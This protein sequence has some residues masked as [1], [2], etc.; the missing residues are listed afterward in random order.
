MMCPVMHLS[1][2]GNYQDT[3][4]TCLNS[5]AVQLIHFQSLGKLSCS[6]CSDILSIAVHLFYKWLESI[7]R[8]GKFWQ[9]LHKGIINSL[10][11]PR[12]RVFLE[13]RLLDYHTQNDPLKFI[14]AF[15]QHWYWHIDKEPLRLSSL[16]LN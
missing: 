12:E 16:A 13:R 3:L 4:F 8:D 6:T 9:H 11:V 1:V 2:H 5:F 14:L 7:S 10:N 15:L